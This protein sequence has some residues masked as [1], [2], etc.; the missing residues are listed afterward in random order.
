[1]NIINNNFYTKAKFSGDK[2]NKDDLN[3]IDILIN[4]TP[5]GMGNNQCPIDREIVPNK[6]ILVCDIVYKPHETEF[7]KW[8]NKNNLNTIYGIDMLI[9]QG[10]EAFK[11][12]TNINTT[13]ED[14]NKID[15]IYLNSIK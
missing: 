3:D 14:K 8:A 15:N 11:I 1:M 6:K 12:W 13:I 10:L 5:I 4:T 9:N 2:I 7:V